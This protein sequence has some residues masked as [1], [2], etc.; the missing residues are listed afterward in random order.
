MW[1]FIIYIIIGYFFYTYSYFYLCDEYDFPKEIQEWKR[2]LII[3]GI[4]LSI[5]LFWLIYILIALLINIFKI[6]R[7]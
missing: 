1:W 6:K 3:I 4:S 7:K 5:G 2:I